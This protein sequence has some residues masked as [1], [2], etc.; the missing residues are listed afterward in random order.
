MYLQAGRKIHES[1]EVKVT[2]DIKSRN[3]GTLKQKTTGDQRK[4]LTWVHAW[5]MCA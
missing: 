2:I 3:E 1:H 4:E 5:E